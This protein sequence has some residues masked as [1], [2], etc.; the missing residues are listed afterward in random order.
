MS[1]YAIFDVDGTLVDSVPQHARAWV[2]AFAHFGYDVSF[3]AMRAQIGKGGDQILPTVVPES[4][5]DAQGKAISEFRARVFRERY[6]DSVRGLPEVRPFLEALRADGVEIAVGSS[7][8]GEELDRYLR[9][10]DLEG[11][12]LVKVTRD[13]VDRSKPHPDIFEAA[14]DALGRPSAEDCVVIGDSPYDAQAA[15]RA[16]LASIAVLTG[17]FPA[18]ALKEAGY[19]AVYRDIAALFELYRRRG[20]AALRPGRADDAR[21]PEAGAGEGTDTRVHA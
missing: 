8:R 2:E 13:D 19:A 11:F 7:A 3:E 16:G 1:L 20:E 12:D 17:G 21:R 6:L 5:L 15:A 4:R 18:A 14:L 10:A 9:I